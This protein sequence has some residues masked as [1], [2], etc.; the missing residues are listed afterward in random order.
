MNLVLPIGIV[1]GLFFICLLVT[2]LATLPL[3]LRKQAFRKHGPSVAS[4]F[5]RNHFAQE[6]DT[7]HN[8]IN[9]WTLEHL[10]VRFISHPPEKNYELL[11]THLLNHPSVG[12]CPSS[13]D[14]FFE[15]LGKWDRDTTVTMCA[16]NI[17]A[18]IEL[19]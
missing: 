10:F 3:A 18:D 5:M 7:P 1:L 4:V 15:E 14:L 6:C 16:A 19:V 12:Y 9:E 13:Y 17:P 11:R 2:G 8:I